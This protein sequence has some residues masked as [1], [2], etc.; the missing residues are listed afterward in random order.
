MR[1]PPGIKTTAQ[2]AASGRCDLS[3][4][5]N[6][7]EGLYYTGE[8]DWRA[9]DRFGG[10]ALAI[11]LLTPR[12]GPAWQFAFHRFAEVRIG[13]AV[14][15]IFAVVWPE[16][17]ATPPGKTR[18]P[19]PYASKRMALWSR[20]SRREANGRGACNHSEGEVRNWGHGSPS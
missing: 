4:E 15:L 20:I 7:G 6:R 18:I 19:P 17:A 16:R 8:R 1:I 3:G 12:K 5:R 11:V 13:I 9:I 10:I 14:T 2:P